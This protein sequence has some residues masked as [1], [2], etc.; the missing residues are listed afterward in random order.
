MAFLE[1]E[2]VKFSGGKENTVEQHVVYLV[3][4]TE[5][6]FVEIVFRL[7]HL[8]G[9]KIPIAGRDLKS[10]F[11]LIDNLLLVGRFSFGVCDGRRREITEKLVDG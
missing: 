3:I 1:G 5:L 6:R 8:L 9:I 10:A 7:A 11:L 2:P 4:R